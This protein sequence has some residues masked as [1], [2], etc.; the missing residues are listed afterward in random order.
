MDGFRMKVSL[1]T[2]TIEQIN[3]LLNMVEH[4]I[5]EIKRLVADNL[6]PTAAELLLNNIFTDVEYRIAVMTNDEETLAT[7][8]D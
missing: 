1:T 5:T 8:Q 2:L 3:E 4:R 6:S 7:F